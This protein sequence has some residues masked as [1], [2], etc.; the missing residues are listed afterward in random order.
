M[1]QTLLPMP[2]PAP[3]AP[4]P[5]CAAKAVVLWHLRDGGTL[6][7]CEPHRNE[8]TPEGLIVGFE[9]FPS[10]RCEWPR[11]VAAS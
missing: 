9:L 6:C 4:A 11:G 10:A 8:M 2:L 3:D 1:T 5:K 7:A